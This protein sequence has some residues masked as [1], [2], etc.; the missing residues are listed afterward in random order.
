M[1]GS[2]TVFLRPAA[3]TV[4]AAAALFAPALTA[5]AAAAPAHLA[6]AGPSTLPGTTFVAAP[7]PGSKGADDIT[8]LATPGV[9]GGRLVI[10]TAYQNGINPDGTPGTP[11]GPTASTVAGYDARTGALVKTIPV[12]GKVDGLTADP[13]LGRLIATVNEDS[14]SAFNLVNP[15]TKAVTTYQYSPDPAVA[16]NGGTDSIA[17]RGRQIFV[18][19][20]NPN[21]TTQAAD[22]TVT[23]NNTTHTAVLTPV[24]FDNSPATDAVTGQP[25]TLG[26]TDPDTNGFMPPES[27]RFAGQL[28]TISQGDGQMIFAHL[29]LLGPR[30]TLLNMKDNVPNNP[31][32]I[33]GMAV[34]TEDSGTLYVVER[35]AGTILALKTNGWSEGTVF[36]GEANDNLNPL[37]GTLNL[38]TGQITALGNTVVNPKGLLFLP[39][40]D[41]QDEQGNSNGQ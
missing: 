24:F 21:D 6:S 3:V 28:V 33:D 37:L 25:V 14:N 18:V 31:P 4:I 32:P 41:D 34:A 29:G 26:L 40:G 1:R 7:P 19:H 2:G 8:P 27:H 16:G 35:G 9:D 13:A 23:L 38:F 36:V 39:A 15:A 30:L 17:V 22:Y 11:G 12:T 5:S 20:S 10:W